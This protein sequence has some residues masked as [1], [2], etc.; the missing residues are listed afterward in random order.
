MMMTMMT[1]LILELKQ[2]EK[3]R[4][5]KG[6]EKEGLKRKIQIGVI[7]ERKT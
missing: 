5:K 7:Q 4:K 3:M 6:E 2:R 1:R